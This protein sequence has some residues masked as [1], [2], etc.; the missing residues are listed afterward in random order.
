MP[1][2]SFTDFNGQIH[3][4]W[5]WYDD[6]DK[7]TERTYPCDTEECPFKLR[8]K[9][10]SLPPF[11]LATSASFNLVT[12]W[13]LHN[14]DGTEVVD[15]ATDIDLIKYKRI[16]G[17]DYLYYLAT[18]LTDELPQGTYYARI[19]R[20]GTTYYSE[21]VTI[22]CEKLGSNLASSVLGQGLQ[23][24][25]ALSAPIRIDS[26]WTRILAGIRAIAGPP[27]G[28]GTTVG[29][30]VANTADG[31]LYTWNGSSW[32]ASLIGDSEGWY[33]YGT[34]DWYNYDSGWLGDASPPVVVDD[35][36]ICWTGGETPSVSLD[37]DDLTACSER[38]RVRVSFSVEAGNIVVSYSGTVKTQVAVSETGLIQFDGDLSGTNILLFNPSSD[39]VGCVTEI[40]VYCL[41]NSNSECYPRLDWSNCGNV[42]NTYYGHGFTNSL[43]LPSDALPMLPE[44]R[45]V[46]DAEEDQ[47]GDAVETSRRKET[48]WTV[49]IGM[50]PWH[51]YDALSD[52]PLH[53]TVVMNYRDGGS[54]TL[55]DVVITPDRPDGFGDCLV[56]IT[57]TYRIESDH[58]ACCDTFDPPCDDPCID[59][60]GYTNGSLTAGLNYLLPDGPRYAYYT[61]SSFNTAVTCDIGIATLH[62]GSA[63][64]AV[65]WDMNLQQWVRLCEIT[66]FDVD[67]DEDGCFVEIEAE[68]EDGYS[69]V[70]QFSEDGTTWTDTDL[71][72]SSDEWADAENGTYRPEEGQET[73]Y[74]RIRVYV[75]ECTAGYSEVESFTC[76]SS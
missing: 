36:G 65:I 39:F 62:V 73:G 19:V 76:P 9:A 6:P 52:V 10:Q 71:D 48:R 49:H 20:D 67:Y 60:Y 12:S 17:V 14:S 63:E 21:P 70:L 38:I 45:L 55:K 35:D 42:G 18:P 1:T 43:Y 32:D 58:V 28:D 47:R 69:G 11:Q 2:P 74:F 26:T 34:G 7:L 68:M 16:S 54:D 33:N 3:T 50:V 66:S 37:L 29:D 40:E 8:W 51:V 13:T 59:A 64:Y 15:L 31:G 24:E 56:D 30:Q 22:F 25:D 46:I 57:I 4:P 61:G 75:N 53:D 5:R 72:L 23:N 27:P 41:D 44:P